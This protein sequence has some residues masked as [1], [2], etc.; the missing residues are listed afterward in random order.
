MHMETSILPSSD[1]TRNPPSVCPKVD[2]LTTPGYLTG[3]G[4]REAAALPTGTGPYRVI[5]QLGVMGFD[6]KTKRMMLLSTHPNVSQDQ[7]EANTGFKLIIPEKIAI[8]E[9]PTA[10]ELSIL[11]QIDPMQ[12]V[13]KRK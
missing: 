7:I 1:P 13:L 9:P 3:P 10:Q 12:I 5:T 2:F 11:R 6:N 4:A 8:T